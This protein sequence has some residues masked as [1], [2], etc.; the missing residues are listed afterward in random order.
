MKTWRIINQDHSHLKSKL[1]LQWLKQR[2]IRGVYYYKKWKDTLARTKMMMNPLLIKVAI[3]MRID[4]FKQSLKLILNKNSLRIQLKY[5]MNSWFNNNSYFNSYLKFNKILIVLDLIRIKYI[6]SSHLTLVV[7]RWYQ[8]QADKLTQTT[9]KMFKME[10]N[11]NQHWCFCM[12]NCI[13]LIF[14]SIN[15]K[16]S[17]INTIIIEN[18]TNLCLIFN[19]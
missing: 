1:S 13:R 9:M 3:K 19:F 17:T 8:I 7:N 5:T 11:F 12:S 10:L 6:A 16:I 4:Y 18:K 14:L 2:K 15:E